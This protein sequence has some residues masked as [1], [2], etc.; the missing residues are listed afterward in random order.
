MTRLWFLLIPLLIGTYIYALWSDWFTAA[1][2]NDGAN[3]PFYTKELD[4]GEVGTIVWDI[5]LKRLEF[6][7]GEAHLSLV[8][9]IYTMLEIPLERE[10]VK[11]RVKVMI[12]GRHPEKQWEDRLIRDWYYNTDEPFSPAGEGLSVTWG[13]GR[14]EY[15]LAGAKVIPGEEL[16]IS[17]K[18]QVPDGLLMTGYP[19]LRL[20][21]G[22]TIN[23]SPFLRSVLRN[24]GCFLSLAGLAWLSFQVL[25][26]QKHIETEAA[27]GKA[28]GLHAANPGLQI[29]SGE[30]A[31]IG[32]PIRNDTWHNS[33]LGCLTQVTQ[34]GP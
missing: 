21:F 7:H 6:A 16:R 14:L 31:V 9:N 23:Y 30:I 34:L 24:I 32:I 17:M 25:R 5:P 27:W 20:G 15:G 2:L 12:Q 4:L 33:V 13:F 3:R 10:A 28:C 26:S 8:L 29:F 11:L 18:V 1:E 19:R 22:P